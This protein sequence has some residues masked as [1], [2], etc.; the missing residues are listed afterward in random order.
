MARPRVLAIG[1]N[2]RT[3]CGVRRPFNTY[4][5]KYVP[6]QSTHS[7]RSATGFL[8][9]FNILTMFQSTHS[10]RSATTGREPGPLSEKFQS[11]HSLRS[12]TRARYH[13]DSDYRV[14][15]HALLAECDGAGGRRSG[16]SGSFNPRTPCGVRLNNGPGKSNR[17]EFQSTHS[18]RSATIDD[19]HAGRAEA[20]SIHAL[21]AECDWG[22][23]PEK[24]RF[25][26]F[27]STHSLRSA[28]R[29]GRIFRLDGDVSIHALL[30][31]CDQQ[32]LRPGAVHQRFNPR[33]PCGVRPAEVFV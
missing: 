27:Q 28:T 2:P 20:V 25:R 29:N 1:F 11:T 7:L 15:I 31:E 22:G 13:V 4:A 30:A 3:P 24:W 32:G 23:R 19:P 9:P 10:L 17:K 21:L 16:V 14:S 5:E 18:L 12:A 8:L 6:F 26:K 33:T